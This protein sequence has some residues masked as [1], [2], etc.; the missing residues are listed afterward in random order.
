MVS[1]SVRLFELLF[2]VVLSSGNGWIVRV[3]FLSVIAWF[4]S[5]RSLCHLSSSVLLCPNSALKPV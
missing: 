4:C 1:V 5:S 2:F 3:R